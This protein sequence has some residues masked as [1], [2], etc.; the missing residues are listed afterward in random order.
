MRKAKVA[1][2]LV[3]FALIAVFVVTAS[4]GTAI[5]RFQ[6]GG[7]TNTLSARTLENKFEDVAGIKDA[8]VSAEGDVKVR[9]DSTRTSART[10]REEAERFGYTVSTKP[11]APRRHISCC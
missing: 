1:V 9:F 3:V 6:V 8:S 11:S 2:L 5:E 10:I 4:A 7:V